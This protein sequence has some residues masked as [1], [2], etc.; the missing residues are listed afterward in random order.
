MKS[1][2]RYLLRSLLL[3]LLLISLLTGVFTYFNAAQ[4]VN[5]LYDKNMQELAA[6]VQGQ[7]PAMRT[8]DTTGR[9]A[10]SA[11]R[12]KIKGEEEFLIQLWQG[13]KLFYSSLPAIAFPLQDDTGADKMHGVFIKPFEKRAWFV[14]QLK[15]ETGMIQIA[16]PKHTRAGFINEIAA[17]MAIPI[18]LQ[19]PL[20][21]FFIWFAVGKSLRPLLVISEGIK[22]RNAVSL[23]TFPTDHVPLEITP[24]IQELNALLTRLAAA[25]A[26][27]RRFVA[28]AAHEL[29][30]PLTALQLQLGVLERAKTEEERKKLMH[31]LQAGIIRSAHLVQQLLTLARLEPEA[32]SRAY[33]PVTLTALVRAAIE[34]HTEEAAAKSIDLGA[35][36][37]T[38][39][40]VTGDADGL[41][42]LLNNLVDNAL[43]FTPTGGKVDISI[44]AEAQ[45]A[46]IAVE[47][48]GIGIPESQRERVFER[49][50]RVLGTGVEGTGLGLAIVKNILDQHRGTIAV[51]TPQSGSGTRMEIRLPLSNTSV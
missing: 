4:E 20:L 34:N 18:L 14:Y 46:V 1:I 32:A 29:R 36:H 30:T 2:R 51:T 6:S 7:F 40:A 31:K 50:H 27:Q 9:Y 19:L 43:R 23:A 42:V 15:T 45:Q 5:E 39:L 25:L 17:R 37:L 28:D 44:H 26:A 12:K 11:T 3:A 13:D 33:Q 16:Q 47:D 38:E 8:P 48:N 41:A 21:G 10:I 22:E 24:V 49:F 35:S